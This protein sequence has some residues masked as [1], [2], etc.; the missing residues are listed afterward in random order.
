V[1]PVHSAICSR[2]S[3]SRRRQLGTLPDGIVLQRG[4]HRAHDPRTSRGIV[5]LADGGAVEPVLDVHAGIC[6]RPDGRAVG[7]WQDGAELPVRLPRAG[8]RVLVPHL[9]E[10][11]QGGEP[12]D[13]V[14][15]VGREGGGQGAEGFLC[16]LGKGAQRP[17]LNARVPPV[18]DQV[19]VGVLVVDAGV[20]W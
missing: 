8:S 12:D 7:A 18:L 11:V 16:R 14:G 10:V 4:H 17:P 19:V 5:L 13:R 6:A 3:S 2:R 9:D 20:C 15:A 1:T